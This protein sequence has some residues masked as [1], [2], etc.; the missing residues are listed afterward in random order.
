MPVKEEDLSRMSHKGAAKYSRL[1]GR[2]DVSPGE[3]FPT[4]QRMCLEYEYNRSFETSGSTN[5]AT[6]RHTPDDMRSKF[7]KSC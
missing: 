7:Y 6:H 5:L 1:L 2:D 4:F 3:C